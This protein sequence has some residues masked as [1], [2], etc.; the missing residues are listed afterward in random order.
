MKC[1]INIGGGNNYKLKHIGKVNIWQEGRLSTLIKYSDEV[2]LILNTHLNRSN[3]HMVGDIPDGRY[4]L[5]ELM[6]RAFN[7]FLS[8]EDSTFV[9]EN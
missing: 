5:S 9:A 2:L 4:M 6:N 3:A 8:D 1:A 7:M